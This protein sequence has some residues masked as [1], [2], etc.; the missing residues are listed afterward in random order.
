MTHYQEYDMTTTTAIEAKRPAAALHLAVGKTAVAIFPGDQPGGEPVSALVRIDR[1]GLVRSAMVHV[2]LSEAEGEAWTLR[3]KKQPTAAGLRK[4]AIR[5]L[6]MSFIDP[7]FVAGEEGGMVH[8]PHFVRDSDDNLIRIIQR[9]L[10]IFRNATG[11]RVIYDYTFLFD[12]KLYRTEALLAKWLKKGYKSGGTY[13]PGSVKAWGR[14][15]PTSEVENPKTHKAYALP[16]GNFLV[17]DLNDIAVIEAVAEYHTLQK[18]A[19]ARCNTYCRRKIM[20]DVLAVGTLNAQSTIPVVAWTQVDVDVADLKKAAAKLDTGE[21]EHI[22]DSV[23]GD[24]KP[25]AQVVTGTTKVSGEEFIDVT[26]Q[27]VDETDKQ[28]QAEEPEAPPAQAPTSAPAKKAATS[29]AQDRLELTRIA[30]RDHIKQMDEP[31]R[32]AFLKEQGLTDVAA[33]DAITDPRALTDLRIAAQEALRL[34]KGGTR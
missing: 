21:T 11:T 7:T 32:S 29:P 31:T 27:E 16:D 4:A 18:H 2:H 12:L 19:A 22:V 33:V 25:D 15:S 34:A 8:N 1:G 13:H 20:R 23:M 26:A 30:I 9:S 17:V 14:L 24:N 5:Y 10:G 28:A 3:G 6:G